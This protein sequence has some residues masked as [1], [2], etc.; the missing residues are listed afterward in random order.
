M[1]SPIDQEFFTRLRELNDKFAASIPA[2]LLRLRAQHAAFN[3]VAPS[4]ASITAL[5]E[6]LHTIAGSAATFGFRAFGQEARVLEQRLRVLMTFGTV[7]AG[8]WQRWLDA[9]DA[10]IG[11][12]GTDPKGGPQDGRQ[13]APPQDQ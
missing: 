11:W 8:D 13:S 12:A 9:L 5:H 3:P 2:T 4:E 7:P 10:Y 6:T 1:S